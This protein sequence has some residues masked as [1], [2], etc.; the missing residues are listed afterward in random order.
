MK[1]KQLLELVDRKKAVV[2][3]PVYPAMAGVD[4]IKVLES[5]SVLAAVLPGYDV[6]YLRKTVRQTD[7]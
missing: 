3:L 5:C 4:G 2:S 7:R 1:T 6:Q